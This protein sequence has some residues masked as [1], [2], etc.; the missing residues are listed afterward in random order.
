M[1]PK[2]KKKLS[3]QDIY[4]HTKNLVSGVCSKFILPAVTGAGWGINR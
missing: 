3:E 1:N 2:T 4:P